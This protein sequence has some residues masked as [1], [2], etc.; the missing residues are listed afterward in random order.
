[1][2][3]H[4]EYTG[5]GACRCMCAS[6]GPGFTELLVFGAVTR[7]PAVHSKLRAIDS[8]E[9]RS[10]SRRIPGL[11][12]LD[13]GSLPKLVYLARCGFLISEV[14]GQGGSPPRYCDPATQLR[15]NAVDAPLR[16]ARL[17]KFMKVD[18]LG[19]HRSSVGVKRPWSAVRTG[20]NPV[21]PS[22]D[23]S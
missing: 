12:L 2:Y 14:A 5:S 7:P 19:T 16:F 8:R 22:L 17:I 13:F 18:L 20:F 10:R 3:Q 11:D 9:V 15:K 1:M 21:Y 6:W 23:A 4:V